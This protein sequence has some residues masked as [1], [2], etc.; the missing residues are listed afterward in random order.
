MTAHYKSADTRSVFLNVE[1]IFKIIIKFKKVFFDKI[2][3]YSMVNNN[4]KKM[5]YY[6]TR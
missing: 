4:M 2:I 3:Y 1:L 5:I 6:T